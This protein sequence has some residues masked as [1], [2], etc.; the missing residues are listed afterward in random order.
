MGVP[1]ASKPGR[2]RCCFPCSLGPDSLHRA[3]HEVHTDFQCH[4]PFSYLQTSCRQQLIPPGSQDTLENKMFHFSPRW[5][6]S[7]PSV[8]VDV[9]A[10]LAGFCNILTTVNQSEVPL[11]KDPDE[12]LALLSL[13]EDQLLSGFVPL[14]VAPQDPCYVEKSSKKTNPCLAGK[15]RVWGACDQF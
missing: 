7:A 6:P 4:L 5:P 9:W 12:D 15:G 3:T 8:T 13:E 1:G 14:L 2:V 11:Y 10:T